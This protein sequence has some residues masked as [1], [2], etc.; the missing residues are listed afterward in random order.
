MQELAETLIGLRDRFND[1]PIFS[2]GVL[3]L[4][5]FFAGKLCQRIKLPA[6]TGYIVAGVLLGPSVFDVVPKDVEAHLEPIPHIALGLIAL[7]IG[8]RFSLGTIRQIGRSTV[9][10]TA[11]QLLATFAVVASALALAGA[12]GLIGRL[13][14][15]VILTL[16]AIAAATAP[17]ATV[18]V[19]HEYRSKG[20]LANTLLATVALDDAGC[21]LLFSFAIALARLLA[22][23]D[24]G[25]GLL[26]A[27]GWALAD[28]GVSVLIGVVM[29]LLIH[30][31]VVNRRNESEIIIVVFGFVC[32]GTAVA[33]NLG[34]SA[35]LANM[36]AGFLLVNLAGRN[37][38]VFRM[39]EPLEVPIFAAFFAIAGTEL[40][41]HILRVVGAV[42][43]VFI[44]ARAVGKILG[45]Y[46][47]A[48]VSRATANTRRYLGMCLLPQAGVAIGLVLLA[49]E[50][51]VFKD[52]GHAELMTTVVLASVLVN[53]LVGPP[54]TRFA[55][56]RAGEAQD[57][58]EDED[59]S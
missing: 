46:G 21:I 59:A 19:I 35:L 17:G 26:G 54:L 45:A 27:M 50:A 10:I 33:M 58:N 31:L 5:S 56:F 12:L 23:T 9:T 30:I 4:A 49:Q 48:L 37:E 43:A 8:G 16:G 47:G 3:L 1:N 36:V 2:I 51:S 53:E 20:D 22:G 6:V 44:G 13:P 42:G 34:H 28:I 38:R 11:A 52:T 25:S 29:G 18:A 32:F 14:A 7:A 15:G 39:L 40:Q 57:P 41:L 55:L 24:D